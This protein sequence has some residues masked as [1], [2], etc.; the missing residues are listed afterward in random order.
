MSEEI[1]LEEYKEAWKELRIR[2]AR[3][4]FLAHFAAYVIVNVYLAFVNLWSAPEEIWFVWV[5]TGW[6]V[7]VAFHWVFTRPVFVLSELRKMEA[8]AE[9]LA[10]EKKRGRG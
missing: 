1:S 7:G 3:R 4:S 6:G 10:R 5:L 2:E 8:M 9:L